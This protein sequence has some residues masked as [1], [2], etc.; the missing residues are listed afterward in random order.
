[1]FPAIE[2]GRCPECWLE[3]FFF[4]NSGSLFAFLQVL[5]DRGNKRNTKI[6]T[7]VFAGPGWGNELVEL[8][9]SNPERR[10]GVAKWQCEQTA[11]ASSM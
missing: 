7:G 5:Q 3:D 8:G 2:A 10:P 4:P 6:G 9:K 11:T 1:M